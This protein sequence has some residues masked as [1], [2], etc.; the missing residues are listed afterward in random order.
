VIFNKFRG[1]ASLLNPGITWLRRR[2]IPVLGVIPYL[3]DHGLEEEDSL[4]IPKVK[5]KKI[6]KNCLK[7]E[8]IQHKHISNFNDLLPLQ[9]LSDCHLNWRRPGQ[10]HGSE[11]PDLV[12]LPGSKDTL[13]DMADLRQESE[14]GRF[15]GLRRQ[16]TWFLGLCGGFQ[17]LGKD[18][19]DPKGHDS[20]HGTAKVQGLGF[21][22]LE[23]RMAASKV[24]RLKESEIRVPWGNYPIR[25]YEIHQGR[26]RLG[27]GSKDCFKAKD[28]AVLGAL[29]KDGRVLGTYLHGLLENDGFRSDWLRALCRDRGLK[30]PWKESSFNS[31]MEAKLEAWAKHLED[32]LDLEVVLG[33]A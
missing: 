1:D 16:G 20:G 4:G 10:N 25:G 7:I 8:I 24:L 27:I 3:E 12:V 11:V 13:S 21:L 18:I 17:M 15:E 5:S 19:L 28:G 22:D 29:S 23:T 14:I 26:S 9:G 31:G 2:G 30:I 6:K 33:R 32:N